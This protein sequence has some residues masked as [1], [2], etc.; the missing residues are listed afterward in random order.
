MQGDVGFCLLQPY[1]YTTVVHTHIHKYPPHSI[2][3]GVLKW[4]DIDDEY[5]ISFVYKGTFGRHL[6]Q[7][8]LNKAAD[9]A[10]PRLIDVVSDEPNLHFFVA[11]APPDAPIAEFHLALTEDPE[12]GIGAEVSE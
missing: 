1:A 8:E 9:D 3:T 12:A 5:A 2:V 4:Q 7:E 10:K 11:V 6:S